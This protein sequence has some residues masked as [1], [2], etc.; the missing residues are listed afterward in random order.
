VILTVAASIAAAACYAVASLL[1]QEAAAAAPGERSLRLSLLTHL[2][3]RPRW[4]LG[5]VADL[6]GFALQLTALA[7]GSLVL[8]QALLV[9]GLLLALPLGAAR[10]GG[11]MRGVD[12]LGALALCGGLALLT[13]A[14]PESGR[15]P[16]L[17]GWIVVGLFTLGPA[18]LL[19]L[20]SGRAGTV[21]RPMRLAAA[22]GLV[23]AG[24]AALSKTTADLLA[25]GFGAAVGTW[26]PYT[27]LVVALWGMVLNQ[28]AFQAG[29]L[30]ASLPTL[31]AAEPLACAVIGPVFFHE[32]LNAS[33]ARTAAAFLA[34]A[35][36]IVVLARSPLVL[37]FHGDEPSDQAAGRY[38]V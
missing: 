5:I 30:A 28:S 15:D 10:A 1:Q 21:G 17:A 13:E 37:A 23:W 36:G 25:D 18:L 32:Q 19:M 29:S 12:W 16:S 9:V 4:L 3:G 33:P 34:I 35:A 20:D 7:S 26:E 14:D 11:R 27:L 24:T 38:L 6:S 8:V 22:A 2:A 31:T